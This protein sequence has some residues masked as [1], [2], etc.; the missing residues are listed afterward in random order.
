MRKKVNFKKEGEMRKRVLVRLNGRV[1]KVEKERIGK[2]IEKNKG[3]IEKESRGVGYFKVSE[4]LKGEEKK[5]WK[6]LIIVG[7][8]YNFGSYKVNRYRKKSEDCFRD[9]RKM[10]ELRKYWMGKSRI[11]MVKR[12]WRLIKEE[13]LMDDKKFVEFI[14]SRKGIEKINRIYGLWKGGDYVYKKVVLLL[15]VMEELGYRVNWE[16]YGC[17]DYNVMIW[18]ENVLG[19]RLGDD[20]DEKRKRSYVIVRYICRKYSSK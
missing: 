18:I 10:R 13:S 17:V 11:E 5:L 20:I 3:L 15:R 14:N 16:Y 9:W 12:L 4:L 2:W 7:L 6:Y 8:E 19:I 1:R